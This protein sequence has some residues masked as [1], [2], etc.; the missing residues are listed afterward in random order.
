MNGELQQLV[1]AVSELPRAIVNA[2][3]QLLLWLGWTQLCYYKLAACHETL[4]ALRAQLGERDHEG[5]AHCVLLAFSLAL[6]EDDLG[7]AQALLP[8]LMSIQQGDDAVLVGGKRNLLGWMYGHCAEYDKA[9]EVLRGSPPLRED[10]T[11]LLDSAFGHLMTEALRGLSWLYAGD[12]R[13]AEAVLREALAHAEK[14]LGRHSEMACNAAAYLAAVLYET[15]ELDELRQLLDGRLDTTE[16]VVLPDALVTVALVCARLSRLEGNPLEAIE[17][18]ARIEEIAQRRSL[19]RLLAFAMGERVRCLLQMRDMEGARQMLRQL[20]LL[21]Q[22]HADARS[23]VSLR[24]TG[25][26]R[27]TQA[28]F[29]EANL[30]D[31]AAL[32]ALGER[33]KDDSVLLQRRDRCATLVLRALLLS[34]LGRQEQ[35]LEV[36]RDA[37]LQGQQLGLVRSLLDLGEPALG[38]AETCAQAFGASDPLLA[39][40]VEQLQ[41][42]ARR[43][44][45]VQQPVDAG[46]SEPLSERELEILRALALS[47]SNKRIAQVLG[48]SPETVKWH[49]RN[50]YGKLKVVGRDDAV[51]RA[52]DL[53]LVQG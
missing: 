32:E 50:V 15:N 39:F 52:R 4:N 8:E 26:A 14:A 18:L 41:Q 28:L 43:Y 11:P 23:P 19:D 21:A 33:G 2:R 53:G 25:T 36:M 5:R 10:G 3:P 44:R 1:R 17:G 47:M 20:E 51:A 34:R 38:L 35:S 6:Q 12:V 37:L 48:I 13:H 45:S 40:Y 31:R 9:R 16:R 46:L 22:R 49:L 7:T 27:Y 24:I 30:D 29:H 42:H